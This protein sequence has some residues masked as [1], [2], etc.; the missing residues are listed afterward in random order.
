MR[1]PG[2]RLKLWMLIVLVALV[3]VGIGAERTIQRVQNERERAAYYAGLEDDCRRDLARSA[4]ILAWRQRCAAFWRSRGV[5]D[6]AAR[7]E[8]YIPDD[9]SNVHYYRSSRD[10]YS[11][12]RRKH[13]RASRFP[14]PAVA[15]DPP[16]PEWSAR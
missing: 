4:E 9:K 16:P 5:P 10:Y 7:F 11:R 12:M 15:P 8:D 6:T 1:L 14:W 2:F 3:A 13:E